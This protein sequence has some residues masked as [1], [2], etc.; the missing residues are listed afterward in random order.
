[1]GIGPYSGYFT[2]FPEISALCDG[3]VGVFLDQNVM[4]NKRERR[5]AGCYYISRQVHYCAFRR[6][7]EV[8][9]LI[10]CHIQ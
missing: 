8:N 10:T 7:H 5:A 2:S 6:F 3:F 9:P 4:E 1:M